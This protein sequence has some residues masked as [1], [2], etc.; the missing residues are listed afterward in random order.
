MNHIQ[1]TNTV[2][3]EKTFE[4]YI[5]D[6]EKPFTNRPNKPDACFAVE[7]AAN[8][9][10]S[11]YSSLSSILEAEK[12]TDVDFNDDEIIVSLALMESIIKA[13]KNNTE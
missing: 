6:G 7:N 1:K 8:K 13:L 4:P 5:S 9:D 12:Y 3:E 2:D 11:N 10:K